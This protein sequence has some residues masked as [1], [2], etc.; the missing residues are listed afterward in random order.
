MM[1]KTSSDLT[2]NATLSTASRPPNRM[3]SPDTLSNA[4]LI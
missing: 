2:S 4:S 1:A 3:V